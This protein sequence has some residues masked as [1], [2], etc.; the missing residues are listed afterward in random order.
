M[1]CRYVS[2]RATDEEPHGYRQCDNRAAERHEHALAQLPN[3]P[4][5]LG[6][7]QV[8]QPAGEHGVQQSKHES[9]QNV[10]WR[11]GH[12]FCTLRHGL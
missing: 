8:V 10:G 12:A 5:D 1:F 6:S 3:K 11:V 9:P 2:G 7:L 4:G